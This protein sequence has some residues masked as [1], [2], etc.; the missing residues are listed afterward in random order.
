M[1]GKPN[2]VCRRHKAIEAARNSEKEAVDV[3]KEL[4]EAKKMLEEFNEQQR[5]WQWQWQQAR[6]TNFSQLTG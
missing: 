6:C 1:P 3:E 5:Q 4:E 2:P